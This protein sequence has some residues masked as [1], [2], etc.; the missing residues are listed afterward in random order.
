VAAAQEVAGTRL[1]VTSRNKKRPNEL[2]DVEADIRAAE[3]ELGWKPHTSLADGLK[4]CWQAL[5][6]ALEQT[7]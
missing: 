6:P 7:R 2:Q 4:Q 1:N 3:A 5:S